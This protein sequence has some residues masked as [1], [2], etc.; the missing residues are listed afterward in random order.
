MKYF[1]L[2]ISVIVTI[3]FLYIAKN[4]A[5]NRPKFYET[6]SSNGYSIQYTSTPKVFEREAFSI[7]VTMT[8]EFSDS[9]FP[10]V[11]IIKEGQDPTKDANYF[12]IQKLK[13]VD[14][15]PNVYS[16]DGTAGVRGEKS[17]YYF[18]VADSFGN[19]KKVL[20]QDEVQL[21][22]FVLKYIGHVPLYILIG[23]ILLIFLSVFF[24]VLATVHGVS[25]LR[26]SGDLYPVAKYT[27]LA[28]LSCFLGGYPFGFAMNWYAFNGIWEGVPFGT[29]ATDNKTQLLF[30]YLLFALISMRGSLKKKPSFNLYTE[31]T[32]GYIALGS[33]LVMAFVN[34]IPHSIQ[35]SK[36][37]TI[38]FCYSFIGLVTLLT[39][40]PMI[41]KIGKK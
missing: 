6:D 20:S 41:L 12:S 36:S 35:F 18:A 17:Y 13:Q 28:T 24:I 22:P 2:I 9:L 7:N 19:M 14:T 21:S 29:D 26:G 5:M 39:L 1:K 30:V 34:L 10:A 4:N 23:H 31:K 27:L 16:F 40:Y 3:L 11:R 32:T 38:T 8:G 37:F 15:L 33:F 25:F